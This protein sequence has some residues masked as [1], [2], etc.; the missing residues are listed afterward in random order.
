MSQGSQSDRVIGRF[1]KFR[2][3]QRLAV[4]RYISEW[5]AVTSDIPQGSVL[6]LLLFVKYI[7]DLEE[8]VTGL[9]GKFVDDTKVCG[10]ADS[11]GDRQRIQ[12]DIDQLETWAERWQMKFNPDKCEVMHFGRSNT[13][14]K[15][16]VNGRTL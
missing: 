6:G 7:N 11:D 10:I 13:D 12:Q 16:T 15:Y 2:R 5:R 3:K 8:N 14:R 4:Q 1:E 9:I